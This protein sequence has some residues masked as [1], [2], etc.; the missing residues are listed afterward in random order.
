MDDSWLR[1]DVCLRDLPL[2]NWPFWS[3]LGPDRLAV[4][5]WLSWTVPLLL[6]EFVVRSRRALP[7]TMPAD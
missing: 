4:V 5:A 1:R 7:M 3:A 2:V 6:T